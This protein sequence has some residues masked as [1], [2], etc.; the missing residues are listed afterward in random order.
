MKVAPLWHALSAAHGFDPVLIH[1]GQHY[2]FN[3]SDAFFADL[4]LRSAEVIEEMKKQRAG[5][6]TP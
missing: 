1:T 6:G 2:D 4:R 5:R 3:M